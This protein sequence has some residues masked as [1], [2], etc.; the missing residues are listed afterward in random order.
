[1]PERSDKCRWPSRFGG[2]FLADAQYLAEN[3]CD[4]KARKQGTTLGFKFWDKSNPVWQREFL[5][6]ARHATSLLKLYSVEAIVRALRAPKGKT[7]YSLAAKWLDPLIK[8]EQIKLD[9]ARSKQES[10]L[11]QQPEPDT[12]PMVIEA[13]RPVFAPKES[14]L[15][16]LRRL[17]QDSDG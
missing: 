2:G 6:Q 8:E 13:P 12:S 3:M 5:L 4:R 10:R 17:D 14:A 9:V 7:V 15:S 1:M 16:K 11:S